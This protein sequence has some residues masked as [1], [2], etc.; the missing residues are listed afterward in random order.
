MGSKYVDLYE[1]EFSKK[2]KNYGGE[3]ILYLLA[4]GR[5]VFKCF[6]NDLSSSI[7]KSKERNLDVL[8]DIK[9]LYDLSLMPQSM[10]ITRDTKKTKLVGTVMEYYETVK[11]LSLMNIN[12]Q[13]EALRKIKETLYKFEELNVRYYDLKADNILYIKKET[14]E[15]NII[16]MEEKMMFGDM[17]SASVIGVKTDYSFYNRLLDYFDK[18]GT[19]S[20]NA[21]IY[22]YNLM[23]YELL[24]K[25][26][27]KNNDDNMAFYKLTDSKINKF[28][29]SLINE[30]AD[31]IADHE[32]LI[33]YVADYMKSKYIK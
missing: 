21:Q 13:I 20:F 17:D 19:E 16:H 33:D 30:D 9:E 12:Y 25:P 24:I 1:L 3:S 5:N 2:P 11:P 26:Y 29:D 27:T 10:V 32:Y 7:L 31:Q 18:G 8:L 4:N 6:R 22:L 28:C 15:N 23:T 14:K